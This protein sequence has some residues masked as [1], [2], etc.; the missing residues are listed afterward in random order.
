MTATLEQP[1]IHHQTSATRLRSSMAA[2]RLSLTAPG[3]HKTLN[4]EQK[5]QA[6]DTFGAAN[7]FISAG[8]KLLDTKHPAFRA[9]TNIRNRIVCLWKAMSLPYPE[10]GV[11]LIRIDQIDLFNEQMT[12][13]RAALQEAVTELDEQYADLRSAA[14]DRLGSLFDPRDYPTSL[15]GLFD[16]E[17]DFPSMEPPAYLHQISPVLYQQECQRIAARF[18]EALELAEQAFGEELGKLIKHLKER[19][20]GA[21]DGKPK[22]FRDS[23]VIN[24]TEFFQRFR[25]L[26]V[27]SSEQLD[28]IVAQAQRI[29]QGIEPQ[30]LR[31]NRSVRETIAG[32]LSQLQ[33]SVDDLLIDRPR[34]SI[35][36]RPENRRLVD[37]VGG[38]S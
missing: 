36:R 17:W 22:V 31:D 11:R 21:V 7:Q 8:K 1:S 32:E 20:S 5:A 9:V 25:S 35:L 29:V 38:S 12:P 23:A 10:P 14:E 19:L 2:V 26:N 28:E 24:L 37:A 18:N 33:A 27:R 6:A 15:R 3:V 34:R 13:L 16:V 4:R 30:Q